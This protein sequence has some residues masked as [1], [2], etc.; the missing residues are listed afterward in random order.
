MTV[1]AKTVAVVGREHHDRILQQAFGAVS[2]LAGDDGGIFGSQN[3]KED[4]EDEKESSYFTFD[5]DYDEDEDY[6]SQKG[7]EIL[8]QFTKG[9]SSFI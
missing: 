7:K 4:Q 3:Q 5:V 8:G 9:F 6:K 1:I 2:Q